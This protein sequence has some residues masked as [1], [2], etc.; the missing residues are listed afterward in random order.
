MKL[1]WTQT[2]PPLLIFCLIS[3]CCLTSS[4]VFNVFIIFYQGKMKLVVHNGSDR[5]QQL[6]DEKKE[7][8]QE[9]PTGLLVSID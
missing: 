5:Q 3:Q 7:D 6:S 8:W 9:P 2:D 1:R 4:T